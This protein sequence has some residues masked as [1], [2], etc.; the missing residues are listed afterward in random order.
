[1]TRKDYILDDQTIREFTEFSPYTEGGTIPDFMDE[2]EEVAKAIA[3]T[4]VEFNDEQARLLFLMRGFYLLG[5]LRGGE[6]YRNTLQAHAETLNPD[7]VQQEFQRIPFAL[8]GSCAET[9]AN[10]LNYLTS[11][12]LAQLWT[13]LDF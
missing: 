5:I 7:T 1:M 13:V 6:E 11:D 9:F 4:G 3:K 12:E 2:A 8:S 10:D